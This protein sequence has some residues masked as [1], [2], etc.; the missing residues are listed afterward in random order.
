MDNYYKI[1]SG[2][3][4]MNEKREILL[5][6]DPVRGWELP[7]GVVE[8]YESMKDAAIR[9]V[10]EEMGIHI[11][12]LKFCGISDEVDNHIEHMWWLGKPVYG[13]LKTNRESLNVG[14]FQTEKAL[15]L[16][17]MNNFK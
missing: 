11:E 15:K 2:V 8:P 16:I 9:E 12:I 17:K 13:S 7:G 14:F 10:E 3:L 1:T 5:K 4:V 6:E